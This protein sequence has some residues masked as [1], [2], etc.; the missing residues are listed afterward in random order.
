MIIIGIAS[1]LGILA[2]GFL[3]REIFRTARRVEP[4][5]RRCGQSVTAEQAHDG[6]GA[7]E[8]CPECGD[9]LAGATV[10]RRW[11]PRRM[12]TWAALLAI[13]ALLP[14]TWPSASTRAAWMPIWWLMRVERSL[15][16]PEIE[17]IVLSELLERGVDGQ[18]SERVSGQ[19]TSEAIT[20]L[21]DTGAW[22]GSAADAGVWEHLVL[23]AI[24]NDWLSTDEMARVH[25]AVVV[26]AAN[27]EPRPPEGID[28]TLIVN[29][30]VQSSPLAPS[31][32]AARASIRSKLP[33]TKTVVNGMRING[34]PSPSRLDGFVLD[35]D[36]WLDARRVSRGWGW[37]GT[38]DADGGF[39]PTAVPL[40][41][42]EHE[43][44][45]EFAFT[46][47]RHQWTQTWAVPLSQPP[48]PPE[49]WDDGAEGSSR[50]ATITSV[51]RDADSVTIRIEGAEGITRLALRMA[52]AQLRR[53]DGEAID[54]NKMV[55]GQRTITCTFPWPAE[56]SRG[57]AEFFVDVGS[58]L[59]EG[60]GP[61]KT[62]G[63][64]DAPADGLRFTV[65]IPI[66]PPG[67]DPLPD[68][69]ED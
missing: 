51:E 2:T 41:P 29:R 3:V 24:A 13:A 48:W 27:V 50:F 17:S 57:P 25:R 46:A 66:R 14:V 23:H 59:L 9:R 31:V 60:P 21:V 54:A 36:P 16:E 15:G 7:D 33:A 56:A 22:P 19:L 12:G 65:Q 11:R 18:I 30:A 39:D 68:D 5:C 49:G 69:P 38:R 55:M 53:P 43:I 67:P 52:D 63:W 28:V 8:R 62:Q 45:F 20:A 37:S 6:A 26:V 58:A 32:A 10:T 34:Q 61:T 44:E 1:G 35:F 40:P 47:G 42:G 4:Q 64:I